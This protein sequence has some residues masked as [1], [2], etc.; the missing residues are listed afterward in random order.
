M[1]LWL[2]ASV[3]QRQHL[4]LLRLRRHME[5]EP[6]EDIAA[7]AQQPNSRARGGP[8]PRAIERQSVDLVRRI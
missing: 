8:M 4:H 5:A 1:V 3:P 2:I 7:L 6:A